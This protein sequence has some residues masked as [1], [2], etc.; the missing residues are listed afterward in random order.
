MAARAALRA[1]PSLLPEGRVDHLELEARTSERFTS[2]CD[3]FGLVMCAEMTGKGSE[4]M[5]TSDVH[6]APRE[7][8]T[9]VAALRAAPSLSLA[10]R[11]VQLEFKARASAQSTSICGNYGFKKRQKM[12]R[13]SSGKQSKVMSRGR[14]LRVVRVAGGAP[15]RLPPPSPLSLCRGLQR[16]IP[17][18][19]S[20]HSASKCDFLADGD[21]SEIA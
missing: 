13:K 10:N 11:D 2:I 5:R 16:G 6:N 8:S 9:P 4:N 20:A 12:P 17:A 19:P 14:T 18:R 1:T 21:A 7:T 15:R 3:I